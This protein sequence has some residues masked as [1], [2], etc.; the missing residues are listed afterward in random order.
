[1][2]KLFI[3]SDVL[4][5][6]LSRRMPFYNDSAAI[7]TLAER[8]LICACT[9]PVVIANIFYILRKMKTKSV[10]LESLRKL[11]LFINIL[12]VTENNIDKALVSK[13]K[14]F[15][16][17]I[18]YFASTDNDVGFIITRNKGDYKESKISVCTP[19]E[20]LEIYNSQK[21]E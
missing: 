11:R 10:A 15:E 1:M 6:V 5:D 7:L 9:T 16:D 17:A 12:S 18:Q 8:K 20:F 4:L 21:K 19:A 14:D 3:D 13:F 2:H